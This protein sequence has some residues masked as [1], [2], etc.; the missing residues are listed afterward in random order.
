MDLGWILFRQIAMMFVMMLLGTLMFKTK[1]L[2]LEG[3]KQLGSILLYLV[4]P[5][6]IINAYT[7]E[8]SEQRARFIGYAFLLSTIG[9]LLAIV[10]SRVIFKEGIMRFSG[11]FSNAGF[12]GIPLV[13]ATLGVEAVF[14][15]S[16]YMA[17]LILLQWTYGVYAIT[18]DASTVTFKKIITN[19]VIASVFVGLF[20]F[21]L[22]IPIPSLLLDVLSS[23]NQLNGPLAMFVLGVY[24]AVTPIQSLYNRLSLYTMSFVRLV[25]IPLIV[26]G[27]F[28]LL[29]ADWYDAKLAIII[30]AS[31]PVG[32]NVAILAQQYDQDYSAAVGYIVLSTLLSIFSM[33][34]MVTFAKSLWS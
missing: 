4:T 16:T 23:V 18:Q 26:V 10:I 25:F 24:L 31:A 34:L 12:M 27:V 9:L 33:P 13:Y 3:S 5:M 19:P 32:F 29:P 20:I 7:I 28:T 11:A 6:V 21:F 2:S 22:K 14:Y 8:Y 1:K 17:M 30:A 15:V